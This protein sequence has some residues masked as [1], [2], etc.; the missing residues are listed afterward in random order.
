MRTINIR[1]DTS[2]D[3]FSLISFTSCGTRE[4]EVRTLAAIPI[5][6]S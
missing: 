6:V 5:K 2:F 4:E 3:F 1:I